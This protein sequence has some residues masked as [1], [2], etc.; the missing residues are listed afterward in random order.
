MKIQSLL[1]I[2]VIVVLSICG[3]RKSSDIEV[4]SLPK[5]QSA[6]LE[7]GQSE[8]QATNAELNESAEVK[9]SVAQ[10]SAP[11]TDDPDSSEEDVEAADNDGPLHGELNKRTIQKIVRKHSDEIRACFEKDI[12]KIPY[13][14]GR[15]I[16]VMKW[17]ILET[18]KVTDS[19]CTDVSYEN[20][21]KREIYNENIE[22]CL[23]SSIND[24]RFPSPRGGRVSIDYPFVF[25]SDD[26]S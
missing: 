23:I 2:A 15:L 7:Q 6:S 17:T 19:T 9:E 11:A 5:D 16:Y 3:C 4:N 22:N 21:N 12:D 26:N 13:T 18:G 1:W 25:D 24:W 20:K 14:G 10:D 8:Q